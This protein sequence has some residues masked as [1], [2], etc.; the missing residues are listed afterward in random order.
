MYGDTFDVVVVGAGP[1]GLTAALELARAR[2]RVAVIDGGPPRNAAAAHMHGFLS[3]DGM[4]PQELLAA[5]RA[6]VTRYGGMLVEDRVTRIDHDASGFQVRLVGGRTLA[7]RRV[8]VATGVRDELPDVPGMRE[9]WGDDVL[10]CPYCHG[11]EVR[12]RPIGVV[13]GL[14]PGRALHLALLLPQWSPDVV[15]F[16]NGIALT[17]DERAQ[18]A[19]RGVPVVDGSV[20]RLVVHD[21]VLRGVE[22]A[23]ER[24]VPR[25]VVFV[26]SFLVPHDELLIGLGCEIDDHGWARTDATG[27]TSVPGVWAAGN[28]ANPRAQVVSAAGMG[29]AAAIAMNADMVQEEVRAATATATAAAAPPVP[30]G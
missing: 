20:T 27:R 1:A 12:D 16:T 15:F 25:S 9:R 2:R 22:L 24:V 11:Y 7:A 4:P 19:A 21:G 30:A 5:G 14:D 18:L 6:E 26:G 23:G 29:S 3:R 8:L 13:G 28:V 10:P 17:A